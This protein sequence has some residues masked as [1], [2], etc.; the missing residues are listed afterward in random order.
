M[1]VSLNWDN[2]S[3]EERKR[4]QRHLVRQVP[5]AAP[6]KLY[7]KTYVKPK[8]AGVRNNGGASFSRQ[9]RP[10]RG[11]SRHNTIM[12]LETSQGG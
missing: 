2:K 1:E 9:H 11:T 4:K 7:A 3:K 10:S 8:E 5:K 6:T 12:R